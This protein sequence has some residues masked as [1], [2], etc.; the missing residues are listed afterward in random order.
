[1]II[2]IQF[3][4]YLQEDIGVACHDRRHTEQLYVAK[5]VSFHDLHT[6]IESR[7]PEGTKIPSVKW[8]RYQFQP[9]NPRAK[10]SIYYKDKIKIKMMVQKRQ[11]GLLNEYFLGL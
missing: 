3:Y 4:I 2:V 5:A 10:T 11:V 6:I 1:M 9:L 7:V 8:L